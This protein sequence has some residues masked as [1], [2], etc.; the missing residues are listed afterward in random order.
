[1]KNKVSSEWKAQKLGNFISSLP[2]SKIPSS[3]S[4][5]NGYYNFYVSSPKV[6]KSFNTNS[7]Q[8][9]VLF[10][11]GGDAAIHFATGKYA[12]S[13]DVWATQF[14]EP[15][16]NDFVFRFLELNLNKIDYLG[17]QGS[18]LK[19]LDK[20]FIKELDIAYPS[21]TVQKKISLIFSAF[22]ELIKKNKLLIKKNK[23]LKQAMMNEL[24]TKGINH[25]KFK[26]SIIGKIPENWKVC[27]GRDLLDN[28]VK[29][30]M[31]S[32]PF[33]SQ[34]LKSELVPKGIPLLGIDNVNKEFFNKNYTR[35]ISEKK[36]KELARYQVFPDDVMITIMGTVGRCCVVPKDISLAIS[37]KHTWVITLD[38]KKILPDLVSWQI[39]HASWVL[40][41]FLEMSQGGILDAISSETIRDIK[42]PVPPIEEQYEISK[43]YQNIKNLVNSH[44]NRLNKIQFLKKSFLHSILNARLKV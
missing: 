36:Y 21:T 35:F 9:A 23:D 10:S 18:G 44:M 7:S 20:E 16:T 2:K 29:N 27:N 43:I 24:L 38:Q 8:P 25:T 42:F 3:Q 22:D 14:S 31:R 4:H 40:K 17:F 12:Y 1:M 6:Q 26:N 33:G 28:T 32:G 13:T 30:A 19:H 5:K 37:S 34:L 41:H 15:L 39:N 11:T